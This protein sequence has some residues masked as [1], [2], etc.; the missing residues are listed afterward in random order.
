MRVEEHPDSADFADWLLGVG[1]GRGLPL[2][3]KI[4]IPPPHMLTPQNVEDLINEIYPNIEQGNT[5]QSEYFLERAILAARNDEV[6]TINSKVLEKF[7]GHEKTLH[8]VDKVVEDG[9]VP[10]QDF[11]PHY[12]LEFLNS[13]ELGG[14]P[15][16]TLR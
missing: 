3:H 8:G 14:L 6:S 9:N 16:S 12:P 15:P 4:N 7:P 5:F 13:I 11:V 10:E 2:D 1:S